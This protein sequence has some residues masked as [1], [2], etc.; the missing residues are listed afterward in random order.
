MKAIKKKVSQKILFISIFVILF[1]LSL[2]ITDY[3]LNIFERVFKDIVLFIESPFVRNETKSKCS[4]FNEYQEEYNQI[5]KIVDISNSLVDKDYVYVSIINRNLNLFY[6]TITI[7]KGKKEGIAV[8]DAVT[9][10][11]N[12]IGKVTNVSNYNATERLL[13]SNASNNKVSI[14][15]KNEDIYVYGLLNGYIDDYYIVDNI[16]N[17]VSKGNVILTTGYGDSF[18]SNLVVGTVEMLKKDNFGL[19]SIAYIKPII[20]INNITYLTVLKR[21]I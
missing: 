2:I 20:D 14:K 8:N 5:K 3:K 1:S 11:N 19:S 12:L 10:G 7:N 6:D 13:T 21:K 16:D 4:T 18:P 17:Q 15:V 9:Y